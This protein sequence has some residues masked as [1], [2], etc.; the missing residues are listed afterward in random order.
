MKR[1]W[2]NKLFLLCWASYA[3]A[4][5]C[6]VNISSALD[7][8]QQSFQVSSNLLGLLGVAFFIT[9]AAGQLING[10]AADQVSP[11]LYIV[12][13]LCGTVVVNFLISCCSN[14]YFI[15]F[16]WMLN[17]F[18]QSMFWGPMMRLL[19]C[20]YS[21]AISHKIS[22]G[23]ASSLIVGF[24]L[25]WTLLG[26]IL[27][28]CSWKEYFWVPAALTVFFIPV[29]T[30]LLLRSRR[31]S[32]AD[33]W[34]F[35]GCKERIRH[36]FAR[37]SSLNI[38]GIAVTCFCMG[39]IKESVFYWTPLIFTR[40]LG[41][42]I[43]SSFLYIVLIPMFNFG[44]LFLANSLAKKY[45][46]DYHKTLRIL[47]G[48]TGM[49]SMFLMICP[50]GNAMVTVLLF[51]VVSAV[52]SGAHSILL[53][54]IPLQFGNENLVSTLVGIFDCSAYFGAAF[55][56]YVLAGFITDS[57]WKMIALVWILA[58]VGAFVVSLKRKEK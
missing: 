33:A 28:P 36:S 42:K 21:K 32:T 16:L 27:L 14:F 55:S 9:Y 31:N 40:A 3:A 5:I 50:A 19:S 15:V 34:G 7:K 49:L 23:M 56:T 58:A 2:N 12:T 39:V 44:G 17:G 4:Y 11:Q 6:R 26:R 51:A 52:I 10:V 38:K 54:Y 57:G 29:W 41:I 30:A 48:A 46:A 35:A 43:E 1:F 22:I 18:F 45:S 53:S 47:F 8:L 20:R 25:S 24:I 37:L 13:A